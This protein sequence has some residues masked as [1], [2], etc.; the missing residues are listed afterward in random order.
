VPAA[1]ASSAGT[2]LSAVF[3]LT[4][5]AELALAALLV[6]SVWR[7]EARVWPPPRRC[8]WQFWTV[9]ALTDLVTLGILVVGILDW[10][11]L[12]L[13]LWL[14]ASLGG[15]LAAAGGGFALWAIRTLSWHAT[16]GLEVQLV[17]RGPYRWSRNPQYTGDI[18][19]VGGW[20][21]L[22][23]SLLTGIL[24]LL[25]A[26]WFAL[27]PRAEEPWL[28]AR[29]GPAYDDYRRRVRRFLGFPR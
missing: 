9:W 2:V 16:L 27:A 8:S 15:V 29:Y 4:L 23:G 28:R 22:C 21:L 24:C 5:A 20:A 17:D 13:D 26:A 19:L 10:N 25:G 1:D 14:R 7:P 6:V 11:S 18:A 12:G 3:A